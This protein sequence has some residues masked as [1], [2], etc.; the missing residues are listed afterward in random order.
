M[1]CPFLMACLLLY[2]HG[3][4]VFCTFIHTG[5]NIK[6]CCT[7][8][9]SMTVDYQACSHASLSSSK[10]YSWLK[11]MTDSFVHKRK[12]ARQ[13]GG[14]TR[15][16]GEGSLKWEGDKA[17]GFFFLSTLVLERIGE[18]GRLLLFWKE[19]RVW[20]LSKEKE[21][22]NGYLPGIWE[23]ESAGNLDILPFVRVGHLLFERGYF[24]FAVWEG[25]M[26]EK[27]N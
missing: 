14:T 25:D 22:E 18:S 6:L 24:F 15:K 20:S 11:R 26:G 27:G 12:C 9:V 17:E 16:G 19:R 1:P 13:Q 23:G 10:A 8:T 21:R 7:L 2:W 5:R 3:T 4:W